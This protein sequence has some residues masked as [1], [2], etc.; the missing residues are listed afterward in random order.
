MANDV[1][2]QALLDYQEYGILYE[3]LLLHTSYGDVEEMPVEEFFREPDE[4]PELEAIALALCDGHILDIGAGA[5]RHALYLQAKGH[6]VTALERSPKACTVMHQLGVRRIVQDD[7]FTFHAGTYDTLLFMMN[8][9]GIAGTVDGL[10]TILH[11]ARKLLNEGGQLLLD[12]SDIAYLY[13]DG[14]VKKPAG[15]YGEIRYQY[16]YK[17]IRDK[18]FHWLF[19]D[20]ETLIQVGHSKGWVVQVLFED[21]YNQYLARMVPRANSC[22]TGLAR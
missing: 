16:E 3:K 22:A 14:A 11:H 5:G 19:I 10:K 18:P 13:A 20:Q 2:G 8:G 1:F 12:S 21:E 4:F 15:Y 6:R 7:Y 17:G 9:I